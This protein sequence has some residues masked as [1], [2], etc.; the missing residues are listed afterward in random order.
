MANETPP[1][2]KG[3][4]YYFSAQQM[5]IDRRTKEFVIER[6]RPFIRGPKVLDLGF[7]DGCWTDKVLAS[8]WCCDIVEG[9]E[10]HVRVASA[11]YQDDKRVRVVHAMFT[12]FAPDT[13][14]NTIIAGDV[15]RYIAEPVAFLRFLASIL[16]EDGV[17]IVT[18]P[19]TLS[20]HRRIGALMGLERHPAEANARDREVGNLRSYDRYSLRS[21]ILEANL[22]IVELRGCFLK[23]LSSAQMENWDDALLRAYLEAGDELPD[24]AWF[25]YAVCKR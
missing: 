16:T 18:V 4:G 11:K 9:S 12:D 24:Y 1:G 2:I 7:V 25:L 20:L 14:Y 6:C 17:L 23:P 22:S 19:N 3:E 5:G 8:G 13:T 15:L 21:E 10:R